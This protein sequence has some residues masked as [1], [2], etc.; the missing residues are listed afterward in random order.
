MAAAPWHAGLKKMSCAKRKKSQR[1]AT[2]QW[3]WAEMGRVRN[4]VFSVQM[5]MAGSHQNELDKTLRMCACIFIA[6][7][8]SNF[9]PSVSYERFMC[10]NET[11]RTAMGAE[12]MPT[13]RSLMPPAAM[14]TRL[15]CWRRSRYSCCRKIQMTDRAC[16]DQFNAHHAER[17]RLHAKS[18]S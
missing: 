2:A 15:S 1:D 7:V 13:G 12:I 5:H 6:G 4:Q 14:P 9:L 18:D 11:G 10:I 16:T 17:T 3:T 8:R